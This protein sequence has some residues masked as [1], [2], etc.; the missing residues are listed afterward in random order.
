MLF[1][2]WV[3]QC[4]PN[5]GLK[6]LKDEGNGLCYNISVGLWIICMYWVHLLRMSN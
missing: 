4:V 6:G 2:Y 3:V 1:L 5:H